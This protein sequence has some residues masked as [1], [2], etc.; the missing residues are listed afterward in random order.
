MRFCFIVEEQYR[1]EGMP[2]AVAERLLAWGH[3]VD[4]LQP[5]QTVTC[6][7]DLQAQP[8]DAYVLKTVSDGPGLILLEAVSVSGIPTINNSHAVRLVRDK[9][10]AAAFAR[11][12]PLHP[13]VRVREG[14]IAV[15]PELRRLALGV[16]RLFGL[17]LYGLEVIETPE[18]PVAIDSTDFPSFAMMPQAEARIAD[19]ILRIARRR[20]IRAPH[21]APAAGA[22]AACTL[23]I[24]SA[25]QGLR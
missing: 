13:E 2:L 24:S 22:G 5:Q 16:G 21:P 11:A 3:D 14:P 12:S 6:L 10:V 9:A 20:R 25:P 4:L 15:S 8:Y 17:D 23:A 18:G 19:F 1:H 7:H